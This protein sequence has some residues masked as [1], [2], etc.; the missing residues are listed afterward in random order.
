MLEDLETRVLEFEIVGDF[1]KEIKKE[2]D[3]GDEESK[4]V[5]ELKE[6][7]QDQQIIDEFIQMSKQAVRG[8]GYKERLLVE[9]FKRGM[10]G[11][12]R[13]LMDAECPPKSIR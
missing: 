10:D 9:E 3:R 6:T 13:R 11:K 8:S 5:T 12:I 7:E 1:L 2:F 4:K